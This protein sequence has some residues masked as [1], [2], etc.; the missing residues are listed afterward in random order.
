VATWSTTSAYPCA[1]CRYQ[2]GSS[3]GG[4]G[5]IFLECCPG[6]PFP[7]SF[8]ITFSSPCAAL[9]GIVV[10]AD[11]NGVDRWTGSAGTLCSLACSL[12]TVRLACIDS[13][14]Q[15]LTTPGNSTVELSGDAANPSPPPDTLTCETQGI[16]IGC[17]SSVVFDC[18]TMTGTIT[19]C[20]AAVGDQL[21]ASRCC[22]PLIVP[23][24]ATII[25]VF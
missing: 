12:I 17:T 10:R 6:R 23:T 19:W 20:V 5:D 22:G 15:F 24:T 3:G 21:N 2:S 14:I 1:C 11:F 8:L 13:L 4:H 7:F 25:P 9:D 18:A 16:P